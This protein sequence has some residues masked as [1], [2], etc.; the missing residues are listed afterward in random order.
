M[1]TPQRALVRPRAI[2]PHSGEPLPLEE[3]VSEFLADRQ[4]QLGTIAGTVIQIAGGPGAGKSTALAH[5]A[6]VLP[7]SSLL[8]FL[9]DASPEAVLLKKLQHQSVIF[10]YREQTHDADIMFELAP[11]T[12]DDLLELLLATD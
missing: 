12:Q 3:L 6:E 1:F 10:C 5:L 11:W 8:L 9:D 7:Q 4:A 2:S